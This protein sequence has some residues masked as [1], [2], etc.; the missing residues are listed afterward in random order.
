[1]LLN[2]IGLRWPKSTYSMGSGDCVEFA[3]FPNGKVAMRDS[4]NPEGGVLVFT[5]M[6]WRTFIGA[7]KN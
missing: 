2:F 6:E 7:M 3:Q 5:A 4:K 1:M